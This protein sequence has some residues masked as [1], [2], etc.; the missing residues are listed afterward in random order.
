MQKLEM[1]MA[2]DPTAL[3]TGT[4]NTERKRRKTV[5][6]MNL[7]QAVRN[8]HILLNYASSPCITKAPKVT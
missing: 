4:V 5:G 6:I 3:D 8:Y 1:I 7:S 2:A